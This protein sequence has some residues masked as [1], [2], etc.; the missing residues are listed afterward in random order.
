MSL[1]LKQLENHMTAGIYDITIEQGSDYSLG[2]VLRNSDNTLMDLTGY[3]ARAQLRP[4]K[5]STVLT[6]SFVCAVSSP[7]TDGAITMSL[8][9]A[10][11]AGITAG[12]YY[13]DLEVHTSNDSYVRRIIE[14]KAKIRQEVTR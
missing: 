7:A 1:Q 12:T 10:V 2:L 5:D 11:T 3:S 6:A 9:N 8:S 14:G 4:K 13:Y